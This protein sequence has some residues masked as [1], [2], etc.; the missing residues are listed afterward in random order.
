MTPPGSPSTT[1]S[2]RG[3]TSSPTARYVARA[4]PTTSRLRSRVSIPTIPASSSARSGPT[5]GAAHRRSRAPQRDRSRSATWQFLGANTDR[6][7]KIT[8][9]GPFTMSQQAK[10]EITAIARRWPWICAAAVNA[11]ALE[12][13]AAGRRHDPD[14]RALGQERSR[15][16]PALCGQGH[17]SRAGWP[18]GADHRA[19]VLRLCR[20]GAGRDETVGYCFLAELADSTADQIS[21][22]AAQPRLDL[23]V[24][25]DLAPKTVML[26]VI[27]LGDAMSRAPETVA[28]RIR[29]ALA[30]LPAERLV[31]APDC[32][33]KY[34]TREMAF[35][36]LKAL[37]DGAAIVRKEL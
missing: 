35:G 29:K 30:F 34:L 28:D 36:K 9:P 8:L 24:L 19:S 7:A 22:E 12:L 37:S 31:P 4:T 16:R 17:Q 1:W 18:E 3:S 33:M 13:E 11:E 27:D 15:G 20:R 5:P 14:R 25:R 26:G 2:W 32:G 6:T 23:G 21:I 10:D